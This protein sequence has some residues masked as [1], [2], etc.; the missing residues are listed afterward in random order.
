MPWFHEEA[1]RRP[2]E[3][4]YLTD[5][6]RCMANNGRE[7]RQ[8]NG[9][10]YE[11]SPAPNVVVMPWQPPTG[12]PLAYD[13]GEP[14]ETKPRGV[15]APTVC[16]GYLSKLPDV[17]ET[18]RASNWAKKGELASFLGGAPSEDLVNAIDLLDYSQAQADRYFMTPADKGG[19]SESGRG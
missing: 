12:T 9:C 2:D 16:I 14:T 13:M 6:E 15:F 7:Q 1:R 17:I 11:P 10:G 8:S 19:G 5:C 4:V 3:F 18:Q